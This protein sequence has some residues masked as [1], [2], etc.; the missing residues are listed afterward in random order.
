MKKIIK[1]IVMTLG[2]V[3]VVLATVLML[4]ITGVIHVI[5]GGGYEIER[6]SEDQTITCHADSDGLLSVNITD[7]GECIWRYETEKSTG[8]LVEEVADFDG[9][10]FLIKPAKPDGTDCVVVGEYDDEADKVANSLGVVKFRFKS[11]KTTEILEV[12]HVTDQSD[13]K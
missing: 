5:S 1:Y 4:N 3:F 7:P 8:M 12:N 10:H 6:N 9:Y 13:M 11:G 2:A